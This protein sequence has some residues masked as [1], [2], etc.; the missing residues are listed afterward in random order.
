V[1]GPSVNGRRG[2][3]K[4][5]S[6]AD[7]RIDRLLLAFGEKKPERLIAA[8]R[9]ANALA[10]LH[11]RRGSEKDLRVL[12]HAWLAAIEDCYE[13]PPDEILPLRRRSKA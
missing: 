6:E 12:L 1:P 8:V 13:T 7:E 9:A 2:M 3:T 11:E 10:E 4:S 5:K